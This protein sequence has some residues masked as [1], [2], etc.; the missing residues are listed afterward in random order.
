[1]SS[2]TPKTYDERDYSVFINC[3]FDD[4]YKPIFDALVFAVYDCGFVARCSLEFPGSSGV[5]IDNI[6][7]LIRNCKYGIHDISRTELSEGSG[8]PRF[9][10]PLELG[11]FLGAMKFGSPGQRP[12]DC[13]I[14]DTHKYRYQKFISDIS[15]QDI[16]PHGASPKAAIRRV[17]D[18]LNALPE[19]ADV[20]LPGGTKIADRFEEFGVQ[21]PDLCEEAQLHPEELTF[22][23]TV[24]LV[25]GW[26]QENPWRSR[27]S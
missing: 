14:L 15:G 21:L 20:N 1:M 4:E 5:R 10:M 25:S 26:Q 11:L 13:L 17:R 27:S 16:Q 9:N 24:L 3:P 19:T 2:Q 23:D 6:A 7:S 8:L 12:E 18:W 22:V